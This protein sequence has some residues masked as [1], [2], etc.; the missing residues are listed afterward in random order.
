MQKINPCLWF[1]GNAEEAVKFYLSVFKDAKILRRSYYP[2]V[3]PEG[4]PPWPP[5]GTVLTLDFELFG[6]LYVALNGG[7]EFPFTEAISL[8]VN[9][10]DQKEID[11]Y[12]EALAADGGQGVQCGW[13][14]DKFGVSWQ[15]VPAMMTE[16]LTANDPDVCSR[17]MQAM[18]KMVKL[19]VATLEKAAAG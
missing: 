10:A 9:C 12:W 11:Y 16:I 6:Q 3:P 19:D 15:I 1:N 14:K 7:P 4:R 8:I 18:L 17:V 2:E 13:L 5:A